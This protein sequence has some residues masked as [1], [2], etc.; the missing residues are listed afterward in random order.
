MKIFY[1][2]LESLLEELTNINYFTS[3]LVITKSILIKLILPKINFT[4]TEQNILK[5]RFGINPTVRQCKGRAGY[6][7]SI[8]CSKQIDARHA[9]KRTQK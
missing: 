8:V 7:V 1:F 6:V 3:K 9:N 4:K 2:I 5:S